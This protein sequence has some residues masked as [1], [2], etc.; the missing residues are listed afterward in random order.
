[1]ARARVSSRDPSFR[2]PDLAPTI[3]PP[4]P[5]IENGDIKDACN[6]TNGGACDHP[7]AFEA[8][9]PHL[10]HARLAARHHLAQRQHGMRCSRCSGQHGSCHCMDFKPIELLIAAR[11]LEAW[12]ASHKIE[13][14][15]RHFA[16]VAVPPYKMAARTSMLC[17][18]WLDLVPL[19][20]GQRLFF[21]SDDVFLRGPTRPRP[22]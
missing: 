18:R 22:P 9:Q 5:T 10:Y 16:G 14:R 1:M 20:P 11:L 19:W 7:L 21:A 17:S 6:G 4:P 2:R 8:V 3:E 12:A 13:S 15:V